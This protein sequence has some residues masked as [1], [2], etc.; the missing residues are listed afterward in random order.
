MAAPSAWITGASGFVG[1]HLVERLQRAGW[2]VTQARVR[3]DSTETPAAGDVVFHLG[4]IAHQRAVGAAAMMAANRDLTV[5]LYRR[6][7]LAGCQ[8]FVFLSTSKV[9]GDGGETPFTTDS[10]RRPRGIYA[11]S[12]AQAEERLLTMSEGGGPPLAIVRPP[13]VYG[14]GAKANFKRLLQGIAAGVPLPLANATAKRSFVAV[15]NLV[16]ALATIGAGFRR[17]DGARIWHVADGEDIDVATLCRRL[18]EKLGRPA[19]LWPLPR[20]VFDVAA[21]TSGGFGI[22][23]SLVASLFEPFQLDDSALRKALDWS[24]PQTL[25]AALQDVA[26]WFSSQR[27]TSSAT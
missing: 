18:G 17:Q 11:E 20:S 7:Q 12:K 15:A 23:E 21:R 10:P 24:P 4:G 16:D 22:S 19:R 6:S 8:G 25:D 2:S 5:D 1:R 3:A 13:L 27:Q 14:A 26:D 9:L